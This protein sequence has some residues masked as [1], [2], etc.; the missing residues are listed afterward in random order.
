MSA[1]INDYDASAKAINNLQHSSAALASS[2]AKASSGRRINTAADD[3]AGLAIYEQLLSQQRSFVKAG[4]NI[5]DG[6]SLAQTAEGAMGE[7]Q[8][9]SMRMRELA[10]SSANGAL[11]AD[12]RAIYGKEFEQLKEEMSRITTSTEFNGTKLLNGDNPS[13]TIQAGV[14]GQGDENRID[15]KLMDAR[16]AALD[17]SSASIDTQG[18]A[19]AALDSI[20]KAMKSL[21][22]GRANLGA[23]MNRLSTAYDN[24]Q[25]S[26]LRSMETSSRIGDLDYAYETATMTKNQIL[27]QAGTSVLAQANSSAGW[28]T[29]LLTS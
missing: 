16:P 6:I 7:L 17:V 8:D 3:A 18:G 9:I 27:T 2:M 19:F 29:S 1:R 25:T 15:V 13:V 21:A 4:N 24:A 10:M 5:N 26:K 28:A 23:D 22:N 11:S 12:D 20:D 14:D